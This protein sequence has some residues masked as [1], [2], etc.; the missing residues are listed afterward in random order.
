MF[1][2]LA[3]HLVLVDPLAVDWNHFTLPDKSEYLCTMG[4]SEKTQEELDC[5]YAEILSDLPQAQFLRMSSLE[6][7]ALIPACSLDMVYIDSI[8][9]YEYCSAEIRA[10]LPTLRKGGIIAGDDYDPKCANAVSQAVDEIFGS[11]PRNRTW[12]EIV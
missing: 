7:A 10:W 1:A 11:K 4:G 9:T 5:I 3:R 6:A 8:H 12:W 2:Q